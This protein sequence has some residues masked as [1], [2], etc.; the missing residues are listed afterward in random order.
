M[1][2]RIRSSRLRRRVGRRTRVIKRAGDGLRNR[3]VIVSLG[4]LPILRAMPT[5]PVPRLGFTLLEVTVVLVVA[6]ILVAIAAPPA[7]AALDGARVRSAKTDVVAA[8]A[9]ARLRASLQGLTT[10]V[11]VEPSTGAIR[12]EGP[13]VR[14]V[15]PVELTHGVRLDAT[16]DSMTYGP[17]GLGFG[18]ANLRIIIAR[19]QAAETVSVSRLGRVR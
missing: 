14:M 3:M 9:A 10:R 18:A 16:R 6:A 5:R 19:G 4:L 13:G 7:A 17:G 2:T 8:F 1:L 11:V 15:H 12:V